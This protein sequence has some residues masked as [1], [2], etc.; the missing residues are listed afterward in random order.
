MGVNKL[1]LVNLDQL[2]QVIVQPL[3]QALTNNEHI[4]CLTND[5]EDNWELSAAITA[6]NS[7]RDPN[8]RDDEVLSALDQHLYTI[9]CKGQTRCNSNFLA[10]T[11]GYN[12]LFQRVNAIEEAFKVLGYGAYRTRENGLF[13]D[14]GCGIGALP[15]ALRNLHEN[16]DFVLNYRGHDIVE[17]VLSINQN[18]LNEVYP[19]N[20][21]TINGNQIESFGSQTRGNINHVIMVFSYLFSQNGIENSFDDFETKIDELFNEFNLSAFYLVHINIRPGRYIKYQDFLNQLVESGKYTIE[22]MT[23]T[24]V[25]VN[26]YRLNRLSNNQENMSWVGDSNVHCCVREIKRV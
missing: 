6:L 14:I 2:N 16:Q 21:V 17:D 11:Y 13:V 7:L 8:L 22:V 19:N 26:K 4:N 10:L 24:W 5:D 12:Y 9:M 18:L 1:K 23:D 15:V 20:N 25:N 3:R